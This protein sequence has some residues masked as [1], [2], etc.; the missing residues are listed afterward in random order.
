MNPSEILSKKT[1]KTCL[2]IYVLSQVFFLIYI[3]FPR[4]FHCEEFHYVPSA[5]QFLELKENRNFEHPPLAKELMAVGIGIFGDRPIGWRFMSTMFGAFTLVGMF[6]W[7]L[8][9]FQD[10]EMAWAV[11]LL[12]LFNQMLYVQARVGMLDTFMMGFLAWALAAFTLAW[13]FSGGNKLYAFTGLML[14]LAVAT[15]WTALVAWVGCIALLPGKIKLKEAVLYFG[16]LPAMAYYFTFIPF[17]F[18]QHTPSYSFWDILYVMQANML[19]GQMRVV[20]AHPYMSSWTSWPWMRRPIWYTYETV[21]NTPTLIRG[22]LFIGNPLIMWAGL[23]AI[24]SCTWTFF[25]TRSK[26]AFLIIYFYAL[27]LFSWAVIPR[28]LMFYYY[29]YPAGM[30]LSLAI[31]FLFYDLKKLNPK[32]A[33]VGLRA[34]IVLSALIFIYF[35]PILADL[36]IPYSQFRQ[37]MWFDAWI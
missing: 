31:V 20:S 33:I 8:V 3:Q 30:I 11:V 27:F 16:V 18:V 34:F 32:W 24:L 21:S 6:L 12:T 25:E 15:K 5:K 4:I 35:F 29:Y 1:L 2:L 26:E 22:V 23:W 37:L 10:L 36:K 9:L 13:K 14:G 28:K 19:D 7:G 17:F